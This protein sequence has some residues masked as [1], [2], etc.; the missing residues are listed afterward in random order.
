MLTAKQYVEK[1]GVI[2]PVCLSNRISSEHV[3]LDGSYG[4]ANVE[5]KDCGATWQDVFYLTGYENLV[6]PELKK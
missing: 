3:E 6:L 2:C 4:L 1:N 5:C